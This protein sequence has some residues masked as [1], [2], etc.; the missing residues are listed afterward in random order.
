VRSRLGYVLAV[1]LVVAGVAAG[2]L[3][4]VGATDRLRGQLD[5]F[6]T[7]AAGNVEEVELEAGD[8]SVFYETAIDER[9]ADLGELDL[10]IE[11]AQD[12]PLE[13]RRGGAELT[14]AFGSREGER[15]A[16]VR[17]ERAGPHVVGFIGPTGR[18]LIGE[19][20]G[21]DD[22]SRF[23]LALLLAALGLLLGV[24]LAIVTYVR[25]HR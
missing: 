16:K 9:R 1:A 4:G 23:V 14:Y 13:L 5:G 8:L 7:V 2:I 20:P 24:L 17:V 6:A 11:D 22:A 18:V 21:L 25:R 3:I 10:R 12:R 15:I 19:A